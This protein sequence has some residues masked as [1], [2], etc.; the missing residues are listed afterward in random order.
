M[1]S[2]NEP[3]DPL[4]KPGEVA[5]LL[6]VTTATLTSWSRAGK[7]TPVLTP[8]G[9][10]RYRA[11]EIAQLT[12]TI[13]EVVLNK[14]GRELDVWLWVNGRSHGFSTNRADVE[15]FLAGNETRTALP[16]S[17]RRRTKS[18]SRPNRLDG[19]ALAAANGQNDLMTVAAAA[20]P[21]LGRFR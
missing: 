9:H 20:R 5:R 18:A 13:G 14:N 19:Q 1:A 16:A 2:D 8:G 6:R 7:L 11:S 10:H 12:R 17:V 21:T 15:R 3:K 4:L